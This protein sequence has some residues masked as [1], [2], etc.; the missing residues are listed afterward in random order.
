MLIDSQPEERAF[1]QGREPDPAT[2]DDS[3]GGAG[4]GE[5]NSDPLGGGN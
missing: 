4:G 5:E 3:T 1:A 2:R